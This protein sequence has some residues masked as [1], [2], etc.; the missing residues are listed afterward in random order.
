MHKNLKRILLSGL[1]LLVLAATLSVSPL[2]SFDRA[3]AA[4]AEAGLNAP[5]AALLPPSTA[6]VQS[7]TYSTDHT[8][9]CNLY[10]TTGTVS[11]PGSVNVP[12]WGYSSTATAGSATLPGPTIIANAGDMVNVILHNSLTQTSSMAFPAM[13]IAPDMAGIANGATKTYTLKNV[14]AGSSLYEAGMT[15]GGNLQIAMGMFGAIVVRPATATQAYDTASSFDDEALLVLSEID[16]GLNANPTTYDMHNYA[17]KYWLINGKPY[18]S[19]VSNISSGA[20]RKVLLRYL[21]AGLMNHSIGT[22]NLHSWIY[23]TDGKKLAYPYQVMAETIASGQS[24]DMITTIP[25]GAATGTKYAIYNAANH[26][27]NGDKAASNTLIKYGGMLTFISVG[28]ATTPPGPT[29]TGVTV[30]P[31]TVSSG[32]AVSLTAPVSGTFST[33][34]YYIDNTSSTATT[35]TKSTST[36]TATITAATV[37]G[38]SSGNHVIYVRAR[39]GTGT[40][41][42]FATGSLTVSKPVTTGPVVTLNS[43][44]PNPTNGSVDV[45]LDVTANAASGSNLNVT[46]A[47]YFLDPT[48][49]PATGTR[50]TAMTFD[51]NG[52]GAA[53]TTSLN[54]V[55]TAATIAAKTDGVHTFAVRAKDSGGNWGSFANFTLTL[56]K[57]K[58]I[59]TSVAGTPQGDGTIK[60]T[61]TLND[62]LTGGVQNNIVGAE[63]F[64]DNAAGASGQGVQMF[65]VGGSFNVSASSVGATFTLAATDLVQL[66]AGTHTLY[67]HGQDAA[68]NW[69]ALASATFVIDRTA[70]TIT[71]LTSPAQAQIKI[72]ATDAQSNIVAAEYYRATDPGVGRGTAIAL[73]NTSSKTISQTLTVAGLP[74]NTVIWV[75]V[76]DASGNWSVAKSVTVK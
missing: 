74:R 6:C 55:I 42:G 19:T 76:K 49:T 34:E 38:L 20:G 60:V 18:S 62:P 29:V 31:N 63:F 9:T 57:T 22:M 7:A 75:R 56:D 44:S 8:V 25:A 71:S 12:I 28:T 11:L 48:G 61:G 4:P 45:T 37:G 51:T 39:N 26:L 64:I 67:L 10:A 53:P 21:N 58:P 59:A 40:W 24:M 3:S 27:D 14:K 30:N 23:G 66:S 35:M 47:E 32:V 15:S 69:G 43:L 72:G 36:L 33:G 54:A 68:G 13:N 41:S 17:P 65:A 73:T 2:G 5:S 50:G 16:P 70:P 52:P 46:D 1:L